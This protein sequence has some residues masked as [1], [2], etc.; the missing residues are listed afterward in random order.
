MTT[1]PGF[2]IVIPAYNYGHCLERAVR[3]ALD[4]EYPD[5]E[6]LIIDDGSNDDTQEVTQKLLAEGNPRLRCLQQENAGLA[7]VR[8]KGVSETE[9]EWL[10][11]LDA[12]DELLPNALST[13][14]KAI[15]ASPQAAFIIGNHDSDDGKRRKQTLP[16]QVSASA[17]ENFRA[18]LE[19]SLNISNGACAMQRPL[20]QTIRYI[21]G[22]R[23]NE[24]MPVFARI[25][26]NFPITA[27]RESITVIH[28]HADSWRHNLA[29]VLEVG[30]SRLETAIFDAS[31]LPVWAEKYRRSFR[32]RRALFLVREAAKGRH[33]NLIRHFYLLA[34]RADPLQALHPR[35]V[36]R[37][38]ASFLPTRPK[39]RQEV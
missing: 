14:A 6:V 17:E 5:F 10:I 7:A 22:L 23:N 33:K 12:D 9:K 30:L 4:Q 38:L 26:A 21:E 11:F 2:S 18:Y 16:P 15:E 35:Y 36:R 37:F 32:A 39:N 28:K 20:F 34:L 24:D 8:N 29:S 19:K 3:S 13:L 27:T 1:S 25:L 31:D